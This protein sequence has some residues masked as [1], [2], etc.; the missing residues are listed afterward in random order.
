MSSIDSEAVYRM[1]V[2][3]LELEG[4]LDRC[5]EL[6]W[7]SMA[8]F[9]FSSAYTPASNDEDFV[10]G[11]MVPLL[12]SPDHR[13]AA[14][15]RK[16]HFEAYALAVADVQRKASAGDDVAKSRQL[17]APERAIRL[18]AVQQELVGIEI[19]EELEPS[20]SLTD[21]LVAM[22]ETGALRYIPCLN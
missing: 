12:G 17:P 7:N 6:G 2:G 20:H 15:V 9:A 8:K 22:H 13:D 4:F 1:R 3:E 14:A 19:S 10:Q 21:K 5:E 18:Q 16:L 11:V